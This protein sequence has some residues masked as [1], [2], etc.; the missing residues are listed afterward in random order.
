[1]P[2]SS[3]CRRHKLFL[4]GCA[5]P[6][7]LALAQHHEVVALDFREALLGASLVGVG[8]AVHSRGVAALGQVRDELT[9][10]MT[11]EGF[12][13]VADLVGLAHRT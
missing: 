12:G 8:S 10:F 4:L 13:R 6:F 3:G 5:L 11:A 7:L 2:T 9:Q 1:M